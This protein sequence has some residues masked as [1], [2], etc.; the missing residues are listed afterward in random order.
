MIEMLKYSKKNAVSLNSITLLGRRRKCTCNAYAVSDASSGY[1]DFGDEL[2]EEAP[3]FG[4]LPSS[5]LRVLFS[6]VSLSFPSVDLTLYS[7]T[8]FYQIFM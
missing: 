5:L 7:M 2:G 3:K 1:E 4:S 6:E 8:V